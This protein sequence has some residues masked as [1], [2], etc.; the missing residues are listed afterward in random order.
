MNVS[1]TVIDLDGLTGEAVMGLALTTSSG[2]IL[3]VS[4]SGTAVFICFVLSDLAEVSNNTLV[5]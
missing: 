1:V 3:T 4:C 5:K 2:G